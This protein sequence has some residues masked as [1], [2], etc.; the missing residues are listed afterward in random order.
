MGKLNE[1]IHGERIKW[2][3]FSGYVNFISEHYITLCIR[4]YDKSDEVAEHSN[5]KKNQVCLLIF[6]QYWHEVEREDT[7]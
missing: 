6:P 5:R 3:E 7:K 2:K 4:E 1:W